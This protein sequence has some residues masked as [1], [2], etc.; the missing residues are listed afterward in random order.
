MSVLRMLVVDDHEA[1][2]RGVRSLLSSRAD[3]FVCGEAEDGLEAVEKVKRLR[4]DIVL[5]DIS[6]SRMD[7]IAPPLV[8][9]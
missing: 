1:V 3:W 5:M 8:E 4:P 9:T 7:E 6:M 2:R